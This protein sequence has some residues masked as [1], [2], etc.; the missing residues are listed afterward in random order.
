MHIAVTLRKT[1][2]L[3]RILANNSS[4]TFRKLWYQLSSNV[5]IG[6][7]F[8]AGPGTILTATDGGKIII[9][10]NVSIGKHVKL[11]SR[12]ADII[13]GDDVTIGDGCIIVALSGIVIGKGAMLAE[14]VVVRDQDHLV[15]KGVPSAKQFRSQELIVGMNAWIGC[16]ATLLRGAYVSDS[17]I[18]GAHALVRRFVP[19]RSLAVGIPARIIDRSDYKS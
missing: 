1:C 10:N 6:H 14:Y 9:G 19:E 16:K 13:V 12:T 18:I 3:A 2:S 11:T 5:S 4:S 17:C 7:N 8:S 15:C